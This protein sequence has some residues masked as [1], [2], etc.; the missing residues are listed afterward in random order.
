VVLRPHPFLFWEAE[1]TNFAIQHFA[2]LLLNGYPE[3]ALATLDSERAR[4]T[5][6]RNRQQQDEEQE[7]YNAWFR[8]E[9][10]RRMDRIDPVER[11]RLI[12]EALAELLG[13][14]A[15]PAIN[16]QLKTGH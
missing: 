5:A 11:E 4:V 3:R 10:D 9:L 2:G 16:G 8:Q 13:G 12:S 7:T 6:A 15:K 1:R 14:Q